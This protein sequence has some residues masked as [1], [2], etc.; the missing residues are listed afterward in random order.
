[1]RQDDLRAW[2]AEAVDDLGW[3]SFVEI[4]LKSEDGRLMTAR[5][6]AKLLPAGDKHGRRYRCSTIPGGVRIGRR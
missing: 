5:Q 3:G 1:M 2:L 6:V 4:R